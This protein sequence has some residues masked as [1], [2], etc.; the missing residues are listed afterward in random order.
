MDL[1]VFVT[2]AGLLGG[3]F[4]TWKIIKDL[5]LGQQSRMREEYKF[6]QG[7]FADLR[8]DPNML[9]FLKQKGLQAIAGDT[10]LVAK[11]IEYLLT[12]HNSAEALR[13]YVLGKRYVEFLVTAT[14]AQ[15]DFFAKYRSRKKRTLLKWGYLVLYFLFYCAAVTPLFALM[16]ERVSPQE[17]LATFAITA[18]VFLPACFF[19]IKAG[20]RISRAE[21]LVANQHKHNQP[22][23]MA[24]KRA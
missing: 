4:S 13:N 18:S 14:G 9:P 10:R 22:L 7:F 21:K 2:V 24:I 20:V 17:A 1:D 12:L 6:A 3:A 16:W 23:V 11:E 8:S 19:S 5:Q 15:I